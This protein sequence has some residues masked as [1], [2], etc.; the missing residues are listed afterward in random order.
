MGMVVYIDVVFLLNALLD[1]LLLY[2]T[3]YLAGAERKPARLL[4]ASC[5][6]GLYAAL[7]FVPPADVLTAWPLRLPAA[8][9]LVLLAYGRAGKYRRLLLVFLGL[10]CLLAGAVIACGAAVSLDLYRGGAY[11]LPVGLG[12]LVPAAAGCFGL[13]IWFGRGQLRHQVEGTLAEGVLELAG[14]RVP[15]RALRDSGNTLCDPLTGAP[16]LV[17]EGAFLAPF[18]PEAVRECLSPPRLARP[19]EALETL[20][21]LCPAAQARLLPYRSVGTCAGMLLLCTAAQARIGAY[22]AEKLPVALS[23]T[24][25]SESKE[26]DAL[27]GGPVV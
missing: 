24:A 26:Y 22:R 21:A 18:L 25:V 5:A 20:R 17:M 15:F 2:F 8:A 3:G 6:G 4:L 13:L 19:E 12:V 7:A 23:P 9:G 11:L 27:W 1:G 14:A 16:V 10:S